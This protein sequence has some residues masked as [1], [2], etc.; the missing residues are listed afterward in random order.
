V[1]KIV[2]TN[3]SVRHTSHY[4]TV[5]LKKLR[6]HI[7]Y[8]SDRDWV[9]IGGALFE[10]WKSNLVDLNFLTFIRI[11]VSKWQVRIGLYGGK[12]NTVKIK[13]KVNIEW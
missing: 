11:N 12:D 7:D 1:A 10:K 13:S 9:L 6:L 2:I 4:I 8:Q 5:G 3:K